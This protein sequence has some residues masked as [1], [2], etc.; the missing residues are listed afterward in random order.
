MLEANSDNS[1]HRSADEVWFV[2]REGGRVDKLFSAGLG[3]A[4]AAA[5]SVTPFG[6]LEVNSDDLTHRTPDE[7]QGVVLDH[8]NRL[9]EGFDLVRA[10]WA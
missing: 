3:R 1:T 6:M 9:R 5:R 8:D 4:I 2:G 7:V 10:A